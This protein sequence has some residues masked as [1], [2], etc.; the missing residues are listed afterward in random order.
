MNRRGFLTAMLA[1]G[2]IALAARTRFGET[3]LV[4]AIDPATE[5]G[6]V[7]VVS[8]IGTDQYGHRVV[9]QMNFTQAQLD[10]GGEATA[11]N[12]RHI[13]EINVVNNGEIRPTA[14]G[15]PGLDL[16]GLWRHA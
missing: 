3:S 13:T 9:E 10:A 4:M 5:G 16:S 6:D 14:D 2:V 11:K 8:V 7:V 12:I 15:R 1:S